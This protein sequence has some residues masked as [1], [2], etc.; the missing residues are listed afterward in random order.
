LQGR[1]TWALASQRLTDEQHASPTNRNSRAARC[2]RR[3]T[4]RIV[5]RITSATCDEA[6][7]RQH[8]A[9]RQQRRA[10]C[11]DQLAIARASLGWRGP[12]CI[13][14]RWLARNGRVRHVRT[15]WRDRGLAR[16]L[17][18]PPENARACAV[19]EAPTVASGVCPTASRDGHSGGG[20]V[21]GL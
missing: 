18:A 16:M 9:I 11:R 1:F 13:A 4:A 2:W 15:R 17:V 7:R 3:A 19:V 21:P 14:I 5:H 12:C 6:I 10:W 20:K 8:R